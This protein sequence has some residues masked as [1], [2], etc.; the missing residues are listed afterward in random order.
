MPQWR[1]A[2]F[3][4]QFQS[5][6][7]QPYYTALHLF[8]ENSREQEPMKV[9]KKKKKKNSAWKVITKVHLNSIKYPTNAMICVYMYIFMCLHIFYYKKLSTEVHPLMDQHLG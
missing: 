4:L 3:Q 8:P 2:L 7:C 9:K 1:L 5:R 6:F